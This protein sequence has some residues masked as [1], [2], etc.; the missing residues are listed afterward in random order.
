MSP[1]QIFI[2]VREPFEYNKGHVEG[3]VNIPLTSLMSGATELNNIDTDA[4]LIVYCRTGSRSQAAIRLLSGVGY[5]NLTNGIN[6]DH[7]TKN[8]HK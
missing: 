7:I 2:D 3:A 4:K 1:K 8:S 5:T 6:A